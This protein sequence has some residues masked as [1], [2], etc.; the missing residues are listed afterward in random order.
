MNILRGSL[1]EQYEIMLVMTIPRYHFRHYLLSSYDIGISNAFLVYAP[2]V[3][4]RSEDSPGVYMDR[5]SYS[6]VSKIF[7]L[8]WSVK[9]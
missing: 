6:K 3:L 8:L 5:E 1:Y 2:V 7:M 4:N 9:D